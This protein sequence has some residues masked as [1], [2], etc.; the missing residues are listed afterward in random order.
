MLKKYPVLIVLLI[1]GYAFLYTPILSLVI[2][3]FNE[4]RLVYGLGRF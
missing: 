1:L 4:S 3:S 2:Y